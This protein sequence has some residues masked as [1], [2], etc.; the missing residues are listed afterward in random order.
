MTLEFP[1]VLGK[2]SMLSTGFSQ[3]YLFVVPEVLK[4]HTNEIY[5]NLQKIISN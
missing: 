5:K 2:L 1:S 3:T 4:V